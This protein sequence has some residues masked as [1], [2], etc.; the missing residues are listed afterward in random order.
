[1]KVIIRDR[2]SGKAQELLQYAQNHG[3]AV[4]TQNKR[5]FQVKAQ[6]LGFNNMDIIDYE[7]LKCGNYDRHRPI[8]VHNGDKFL[9]YL[10]EKDYGISIIGFTATTKE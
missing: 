9:Q 6:S 2:D 8:V 3:A 10:I 1:M 5:A 4:I 7:D